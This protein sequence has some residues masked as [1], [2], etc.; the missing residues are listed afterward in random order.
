MGKPSDSGLALRGALLRACH[1]KQRAFVCDR[2]GRVVACCSRR[3]GKSTAV[4]VRHALTALEYP[5]ETSFYINRS[6][7]AGIDVL[8]PALRGLQRAGVELG[9]RPS[10]RNG[11]TYWVFPNGHRLWIAGCRDRG[12]IDNFRGQPPAACSVDEAQQFTF[13]QELIE[14]A[15]EPGLL[16]LGGWLALDQLQHLFLLVRLP[17][18]KIQF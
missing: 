13:L 2:S 16:D 5:R 14:E 10:V 11:R 8:S 6:V 15:L 3:A 18:R 7:A 17:I 12:E 1:P 9:I 4:L